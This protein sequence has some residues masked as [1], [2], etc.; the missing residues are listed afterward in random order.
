MILLAALEENIATCWLG[1]L[2]RDALRK[3]LKIAEKYELD[4]LIALGYSGETSVSEEMEDSIK[5][6]KD[7]K[8]VLHVPKRR[9]EDILWR[10]LEGR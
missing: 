2:D 10:N 1:S 6:W 9:L 4:S 5:Y 7:E 8:G 3:L